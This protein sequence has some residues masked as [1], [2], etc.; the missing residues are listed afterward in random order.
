MA[1][2][3]DAVKN[4]DHRQALV[5]LLETLAHQ[6]DTTEAQIHAQLAAQYRAAW[7]ELVEID[8]GATPVEVSPL[9]E[10]AARRAARDGDAADRPRAAGDRK[11]G[12]R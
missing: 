7:A 4:N 5:T 6:L 10:I 3:L 2:N 8:K 12:S 9:D 11:P 1:T